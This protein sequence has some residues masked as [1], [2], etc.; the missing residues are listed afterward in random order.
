MRLHSQPTG[1]GENM[2]GDG[3]DPISDAA[4]PRPALRYVPN[5][6]GQTCDDA[7]AD[8]PTLWYERRYGD[9]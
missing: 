4:L 5:E 3:Y 8:D 2:T 7:E 1:E 6:W 9:D